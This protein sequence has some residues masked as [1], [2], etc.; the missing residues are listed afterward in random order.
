MRIDDNNDRYLLSTFYLL[1]KAK[2]IKG[3]VTFNPYNN[4]EDTSYQ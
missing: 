2:N 4:P 1:D 3:A